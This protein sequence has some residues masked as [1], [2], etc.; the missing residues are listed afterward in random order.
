MQMLA[1]TECLSDVVLK[2][3]HARRRRR[4]NATLPIARGGKILDV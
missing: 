2:H 1:D 4:V 3:Q